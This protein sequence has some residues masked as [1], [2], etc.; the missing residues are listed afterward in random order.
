MNKKKAFLLIA[1]FWV[2]IIGSFVTYKEYTLRTGREVLLKTRPVDPRDLFRGDYVILR[3]DISQFD[4]R[5]Y[6]DQYNIAFKEGDPIFVV[7]DTTGEFAQIQR[8]YEYPPVGEF[9]IKGRVSNAST[10]NLT[11]D[12]GLESYFVPEGKGWTIEQQRNQ[13]N[14]DV[15]A[16]VDKGG[17][18]VI[19]KL[20]INGEG[21]RFE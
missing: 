20:L 11:V 12:Y 17:R 4:P 14:V 7:L 8:V 19:K 3:Y 18:A 21:V 5:N 15:L 6:T 1:A 13:G 16:A 10:A 2:A 9:Y